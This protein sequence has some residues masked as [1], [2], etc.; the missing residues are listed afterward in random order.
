MP[1]LNAPDNELASMVLASSKYQRW[2]NLVESQGN[3]ILQHDIL[4][5]I[6]RTPGTWYVALIDCL[7]LTPEE[8]IIKRCVTI[9]G[10]SVVIV[11]ILQ[12]ID[13]SQLYT[14]M[15]EQRCI[16]DGALHIGFPAGST[17]EIANFR[18][19]ACQELREETG[20]E[21]LPEELIELSEG[22]SLN[23]SLSD[24]LIYFYAFRKDV[25]RTWLD[26]I[27]NSNSGIHG[28]GEYIKVKVLTLSDSF[29]MAT[30]STLIGE[31]LVRKVLGI[32]I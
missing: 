22:I 19:M 23:S 18:S 26:S 28:E 13:D 7:L 1:G 27:D 14:I 15:V 21:I 9:R 30:P 25:T 10:E 4:S 5:V 16:C 31:S 20:I 17:D 6:S 3:K 24:D 29:N 12:C 11:P 2:R 32:Y 8:N